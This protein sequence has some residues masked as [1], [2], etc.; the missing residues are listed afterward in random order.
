MKIEPSTA[1]ASPQTAQQTQQQGMSKRDAAIAKFMGGDA[2]VN[3]SQSTPVQNASRVSPEE[4]MFLNAKAA[5]SKGQSDSSDTSEAKAATSTEGTEVEAEKPISSQFA[6]LARKEKAVRAKTQEL[7]A[8]EAELATRE[9][10]LKSQPE[11]KVDTSKFISIEQL[12]ESPV[13]AL[14]RAGI[15]YEQI[16]QMVLN[17][18]QVDPATKVMMDQ[19]KAQIQELKDANES[20]KKSAV[21]QQ[22]AAYKQAV[23]GIRRDAQQLV[24]SEPD[25]YEMIAST[26]SVDDIV[27]LIEHTFKTDGILISTEE[28]AREI[29]E[30]LLEEA[31]KLANAKKIQ[32][33][34]APAKQEA[35]KQELDNKQPQMK[36]LTN[37]VG[38]SRPLS[39]RERAVLAFEGKLK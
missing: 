5:E 33:R 7:R 10:A 19:L 8:K 32:K 12:Q 4:S 17:Q 24:K 18:P 34:L 29:E 13:E 39:A 26:G 3:Q 16:T 9:A 21:E 23:E 38:S 14:L 22:S 27:S 37:A 25:T 30:Y 28:A 20:S 2:Q 35:E 11:Q 6:V 36:T 31:Y 15:T 1:N